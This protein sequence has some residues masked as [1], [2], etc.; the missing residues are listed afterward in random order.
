LEMCGTRA[1]RSGLQRFLWLCRLRCWARGQSVN[2]TGRQQE[3]QGHLAGD[4]AAAVA[5]VVAA[6]QEAEAPWAEAVEPVV[7]PAS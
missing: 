2:A 6:H 4:P 7:E 5:D 3:K 1:L